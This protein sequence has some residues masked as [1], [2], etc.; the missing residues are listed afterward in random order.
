MHHNAMNLMVDFVQ[1]YDVAGLVVADMGSL[2]VNGTFKQLFAG[3]Y[4]G[5]DIRSGKNVDVIIG[6]EA[7]NA[8][9]PGYF[10]LVIS[11]N[12]LEHVEIVSEFMAN[13]NMLLK[14]GGLIC[15]IAP[16]SGPVHEFPS[17]YRNYSVEDIEG[18]LRDAGFSV[19]ESIITK[20]H[21]F[22]DIRCVGKKEP[23]CLKGSQFLDGLF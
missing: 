8:S 1:K 22:N 4:V 9:V 7:W 14:P 11:G 10:D 17:W 20:S 19:V 15:I 18:H 23:G 16:S 3:E 6:S 5:F 12:T 13:C 21:P 2:D